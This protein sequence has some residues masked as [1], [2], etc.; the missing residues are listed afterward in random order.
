[1][2]QENRVAAKKSGSREVADTDSIRDAA[3]GPLIRDYR[4]LICGHLRPPVLA[5]KKKRQARGLPS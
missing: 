1:M 5:V 2:G 3:L 4:S